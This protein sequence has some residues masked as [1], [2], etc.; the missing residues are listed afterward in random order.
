M[1][2]DPCRPQRVVRDIHMHESIQGLLERSAKGQS[3]EV[4][5]ALDFSEDN[6]IQEAAASHKGG[7]VLSWGASLGSWR[8][9]LFGQ[10]DPDGV[11]AAADAHSAAGGMH[12]RG[13]AA[14]EDAGTW[15]ADAEAGAGLGEGT[16]ELDPG[17]AEALNWRNLTMFS[18]DIAAFDMLGEGGSLRTRPMLLHKVANP[19][20]MHYLHWRLQH[21]RVPKQDLLFG[22][23]EQLALRDL[24]SVHDIF[25]VSPRKKDAD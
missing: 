24:P 7:G 3:D 6:G 8:R 4:G 1:S 20:H 21:C 10:R 12:G 17:I 5:H 22:P 9:R 2:N 16:G 15:D 19:L 13:R 25:R 11:G 23:G 18:R 14:G